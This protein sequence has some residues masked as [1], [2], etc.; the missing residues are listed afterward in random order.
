MRA[1]CPLP[2]ATPHLCAT[3]NAGKAGWTACSRPPVCRPC[4][5]CIRD[6]FKTFLHARIPRVDCPEHG[7]LQVNVPWAESKARFT[8]LMEL[9]LI[10]I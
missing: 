1:A 3:P 9:S 10:H 6:R 2:K 5:M 8:I 7:V 4:E